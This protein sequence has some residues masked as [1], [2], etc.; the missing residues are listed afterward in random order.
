LLLP[1]LLFAG[2]NVVVVGDVGRGNTLVAGES[3]LSWDGE[4]SK[5]EDSDDL[6][7]DERGSS[8][9]FR[10]GPSSLPWWWWW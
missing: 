3:E 7:D 10:F 5:E 9:S 8:I 4:S 6:L 1:P 2:P